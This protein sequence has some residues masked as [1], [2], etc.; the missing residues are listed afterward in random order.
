MLFGKN[1]SA[2]QR[3][4]FY[5]TLAANFLAL[6]FAPISIWLGFSLNSWLAR[7]VLSLEYG[8]FLAVTRPGVSHDLHVALSQRFD[9]YR[10]VPE[11]FKL[12]SVKS[13]SD[14]RILWVSSERLKQR[15]QELL[16]EVSDLVDML[17]TKFKNDE[18]LT[19]QDLLKLGMSPSALSNTSQLWGNVNRETAKLETYMDTLRDILGLLERTNSCSVFVKALVQN[20]G[21][22]TGIVRSEASILDDNEAVIQASM[23]QGLRFRGRGGGIAVKVQNT[24][25]FALSDISVSTVGTVPANSVTELWFV[26][27]DL[28]PSKACGSISEA[29]SISLFDVDGEVLE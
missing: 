7:P 27:N 23:V 11:K 5:G 20:R 14:D 15:A 3:E 10:D 29:Y 1:I 13:D 12:P 25:D 19:E 9:Y 6:L 8:T 21:S 22:T 16:V 28:L 24:G 26:A 18:S 17:D 2:Q 4:N